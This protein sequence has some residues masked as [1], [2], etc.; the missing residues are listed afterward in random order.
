MSEELVSER[1]EI[2]KTMQKI[3]NFDDVTKENK[4]KKKKI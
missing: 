4:K 1:E 3:I 2:N